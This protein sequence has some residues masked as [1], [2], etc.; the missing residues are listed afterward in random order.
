MKTQ[1]KESKNV[2]TVDGKIKSKNMAVRVA[3]CGCLLGF[4][5]LL[6]YVEFL[7]PFSFGIPGVKLG[8]AN[9]AVLLCL[10]RF[11]W[12]E[13]LVVCIARILIS[14]F[15]F[16]NSFS[17]L[18]S[19]AGGL[20]SFVMMCLLKRIKNIGIGIVS[21]SGGIFHNLAQLCVA[22][23]VVKQGV[24]FYYVPFLIFFG[25]LTGV[26]NGILAKLIGERLSETKRMGE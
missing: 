23:F 26:L 14:S 2:K 20:L 1:D 8:L 25:A 9:L 3:F 11:G 24:I 16:G 22:Y 21:M 13:A 7:I 18:Y 17:L 10:Y 5:L 15:L 4:A 6:G 12:K 19:L